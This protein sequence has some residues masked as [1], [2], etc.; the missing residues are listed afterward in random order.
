MER[1]KLK[2]I[3]IICLV[4]HLLV[5]FSIFFETFLL[6]YLQDN[7][8]HLKL[9]LPLGELGIM[10]NLIMSPFYAFISLNIIVL[11]VVNLIYDKKNEKIGYATTIISMVFHISYYMILVTGY[12]ITSAL[13]IA[14]YVLQIIRASLINKNNKA[15]KLKNLENH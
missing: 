4:I 11:S 5:F 3:N 8:Y 15:L 13:I 2:V 10:L 9:F 14:A 6:T 1:K 12:F 7:F